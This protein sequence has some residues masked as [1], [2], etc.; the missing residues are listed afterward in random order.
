MLRELQ[1]TKDKPANTQYKSGEEGNVI[2]GMAVVKDDTNG[3]FGFA[4]AETAADL[5]FVDKERIPTGINAARTDM[6]DYDEDFVTVMK[7]EFGKLIAYYVG[8]RFAVDQ[9]TG[10]FAIGDRLAA[11]TDG[12]LVKAGTGVASKYVYKGV[13]D[14]NGHTLAIVEVSDTSVA[15]ATAD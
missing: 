6:S 3:T 1:V 10:E 14:D 4:T 15:N 11:G 2:T 7:D 12:K 13:H 9:Y 8:E 5:F